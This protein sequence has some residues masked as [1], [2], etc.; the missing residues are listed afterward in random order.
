MGEAA[1]VG[2]VLGVRVALGRDLHLHRLG[3]GP[4]RD[5]D[6]AAD[7]RRE[8]GGHPVVVFGRDRV[9]L[10]IV[11]A[12]AAD[13]EAQEGHARRRDHVVELVVP[14]RLE[15]GLG[16]LGREGA[17]AEEPGRGHGQRVVGRQLVAG[18]LPVDELVVGHV[19]R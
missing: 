14:G 16:Q 6:L 1:V 13:R 11:A 8:G 19:A 18:E 4:G 3:A 9:V 15:F 17:R 10:V 2:V 12:G 5:V 7:R